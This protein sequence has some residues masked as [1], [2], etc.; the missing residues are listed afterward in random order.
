MLSERTGHRHFLI[1]KEKDCSGV[2]LR[3]QRYLVSESF[4]A[5]KNWFNKF[6]D[7][8]KRMQAARAGAGSQ[9]RKFPNPANDGRE[10][11]PDPLN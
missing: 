7:Y 2:S 1:V 11:F 3:M 8:C 4:V 5:G 10:K 9:F 6:C